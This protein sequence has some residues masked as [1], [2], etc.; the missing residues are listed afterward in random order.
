[1]N[2]DGNFVSSRST[3]PPKERPLG[4]KIH[5]SLIRGHRRN[6]TEQYDVDQDT[7]TSFNMMGRL[8]KVVVEID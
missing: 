1:M 7:A 5:V 4:N 3:T 6:D 2:R 8:M